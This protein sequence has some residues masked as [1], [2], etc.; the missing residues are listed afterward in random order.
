MRGG[1]LVVVA[2][3]PDDE[4]LGCGSLIA[5]AVNR[6]IGVAVIALT[7]GDASHPGSQRWPPA[8]LGALRAAEMR[9]ALARL[10]AGNAPIRRLGWRDG[11]VTTDGDAGRLA[12]VLVELRAGVVLVTS[13]ADHHPDHQ[14]A[15]RLARAAT[16]RLGLALVR[17]AVWSRVGGPKHRPDQYRAAKH[18]AMAAHR[19]QVAPYIAD[20]PG[21]FRL[22]PTALASLTG[23]AE[24]FVSDG[25]WWS[26]GGSNP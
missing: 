15:A 22:S 20:D 21:G 24:T 10:G 4:T 14:A 9:R 16:R 7:D 2:P 11:R 23:G 1:R 26:R 5:R 13:D 25:P 17:Y 19:S 6:S 8:A 12:R 3:H 18:W